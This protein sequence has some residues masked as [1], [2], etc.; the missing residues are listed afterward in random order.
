MLVEECHSH[1]D[2]DG[3]WEGNQK[4]RNNSSLCVPR[5]CHRTW[6]IDESEV[7]AFHGGGGLTI[8]KNMSEKLLMGQQKNSVSKGACRQAW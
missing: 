5:G 4:F 2:G 6:Q 8:R 1:G 7:L 3:V